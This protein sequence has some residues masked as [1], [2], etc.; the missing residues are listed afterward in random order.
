[1]EETRNPLKM[2]PLFVRLEDEELD[3][4]LKASRR[5]EYAPG[6]TIVTEGDQGDALFV[7]LEGAVDVIK[8][9]ATGN[10]KL[11]TLGKMNCFG[12][13]SLIDIEPRSASV[14]AVVQT[15]LLKIKSND[16]SKIL[17]GRPEIHAILATNIARILSRRLRT[18]DERMVKSLEGKEQ[19]PLSLQ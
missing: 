11:V 16:L 10:V 15:R 6:E 8:K 14:I 17:N 5:R 12:E 2:T 13:M 3:L 9:G 1:M 18:V 19:E 4:I 7:I